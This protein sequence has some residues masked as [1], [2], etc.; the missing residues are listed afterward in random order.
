MGQAK[1]PFPNALTNLTSLH[2]V[3]VTFETTFEHL[4]L[5]LCG[6]H[7]HR[8]WLVNE[9]NQPIG[10]ITLRDVLKIMMPIMHETKTAPEVRYH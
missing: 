5:K 6:Y 10:V 4:L 8:V 7:I 1:Q 9:F 2:P 3:T